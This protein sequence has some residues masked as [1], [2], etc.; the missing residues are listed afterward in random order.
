MTDN[1]DNLLLRPASINDAKILYLWRNDSMT[2]LSSHNTNKI[3]WND[4]INWL[5]SMLD[6]KDKKIF[7][8]KSNGKPV[9]T[10]RA[11]Y[12]DNVY[13]LS[14]TVSPESRGKDIGKK[15]VRLLANKINAP[16]RA[17][18]KKENVASAKIAEYSGMKLLRED[19]NILYYQRD[20]INQS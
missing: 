10:V 16:I 20:A 9:G 13:K 2:R 5:K 6:N 17:E 12:I 18:I 1:I 3:K 11:E 15:M 14:W 7:I 8:A 19:S 4:H